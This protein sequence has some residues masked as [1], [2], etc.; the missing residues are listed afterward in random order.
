VGVDADQSGEQRQGGATSNG[1]FSGVPNRNEWNQANTTDLYAQANWLL[2]DRYTLVTGARNTTAR[3]KST[4]QYLTDGNDGSGQVTYHATNPV[5]GLT[6]HATPTWNFYANSG[7]GFET[8]TLSET[9]YTTIS[10]TTLVNGLPVVNQQIQGTFNP[11]LMAAT[12]RHLEVG[13]K[14]APGTG[15]RLNVALFD[16]QT[17]NEIVT[18]FSSGGKT[19]YKNASQ[20]H[21]QGLELSWQQVWDKFWRSDASLTAM[22]AVYD[23]GF[24]SVS[25]S[26]NVSTT[27]TINANNRLPAIPDRLGYAALHWSQTGWGARQPMGWLATAE[28]MG[29]S[30]LWAN[31]ANT[32]AAGGYGVVNLKLRH[33]QAWAGGTFEPYLGIDN[34][35]D[36]PVVG[37]VIVNQSSKAY[38]EPALPRTWV[39]GLQAKWL[40]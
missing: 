19:A 13:A 10:T 16:I 2:S 15:T 1:Q 14:Y 23:Q 30:R 17:Q 8:P 25:V 29:R 31:D 5:L 26:N 6:W 22:R 27:T 39:L 24:S 37:S 40:L 28:W 20:T 21:R 12:S 33:R 35:Q 4:D 38:Y 7:R 11:A 9:A 3:L 18:D 34:L 32:Y 36:K